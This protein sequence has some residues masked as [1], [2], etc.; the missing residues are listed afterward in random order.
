M[1]TSFSLLQLIATR[2]ASLQN[3]V[4][5]INLNFAKRI[6]KVESLLSHQELYEYNFLL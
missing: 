3:S 2:D 6:I 4:R 5:V 1:Q